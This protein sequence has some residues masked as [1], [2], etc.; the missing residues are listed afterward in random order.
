MKEFR[1][2]SFPFQKNFFFFWGGG[3]LCI[4]ISLFLK[5]KKMQKKYLSTHVSLSEKYLYQDTKVVFFHF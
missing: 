2:F 1:F 3:Y 4:R 5:K